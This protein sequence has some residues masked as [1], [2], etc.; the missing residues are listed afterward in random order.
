ML[1]A[2]TI[3]EIIADASRMFHPRCSIAVRP[4]ESPILVDKAWLWVEALI[5]SVE[6]DMAKRMD[7]G[8]ESRWECHVCGL[9]PHYPSDTDTCQRSGAKVAE[10]A[11]M[12]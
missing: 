12:Y 2:K 5:R 4:V 6:L 9:S 1:L 10:V 11:D 3:S 7:V 8:D